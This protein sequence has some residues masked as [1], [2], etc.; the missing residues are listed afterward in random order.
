MC[1]LCQ[2]KSNFSLNQSSHASISRLLV[3]L[4]FYQNFYMQ[5][6]HLSIAVEIKWS[7]KTIILYA[8]ITS[9]EPLYSAEN[10]RGVNSETIFERRCVFDV[11][12]LYNRSIREDV[13]TDTDDKAIAAPANIGGI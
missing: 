11:G 6:H 8:T 3:F 5:Y 12:G 1:I 10:K 9:K 13:T 2:C 7:I 4:T